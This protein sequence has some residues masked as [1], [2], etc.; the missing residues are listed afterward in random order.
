M[1][2]SRFWGTSALAAVVLAVL[3]QWAFPYGALGLV[4]PED[5]E[6]VYLLLLWT[7]G[8]LA[9]CFGM[10]GIFGT[11]LGFREVAEAGSLQAAVE[12]K[13]ESLKKASGSFYNFAGWIVA[14]G[15]FLI[16]IYFIVWQSLTN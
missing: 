1:T 9:I 13:R 14:T 3:L 15:L 6:R 4:T 2:A 8:V 10:A 16:G 11:S 7:S 5:R 12:A